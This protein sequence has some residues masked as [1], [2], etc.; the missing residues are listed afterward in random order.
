MG[1]DG[2]VRSSVGNAG[3]GEASLELVVVKEALLGVVDFAG[4]DLSGAGGARASTA[5]VRKVH[6]SLLRHIKDVLVA[7]NLDGLCVFGKNKKSMDQSQCFFPNFNLFI[8]F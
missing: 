7:R 1:D 4:G 5:R 6:T 2:G 3:E 8:I